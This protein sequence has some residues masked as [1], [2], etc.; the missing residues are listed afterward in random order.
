MKLTRDQF[1]RERDYGIALQIMKTLLKKGLLTEKEFHRANK[2]LIAKYDPVW[3][4]Y[5]DVIG[6]SR[7]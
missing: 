7:V 4:H 6:S 5:P 2:R 3:G 1:E